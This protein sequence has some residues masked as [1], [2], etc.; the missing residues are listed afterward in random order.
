M[1]GAST[2]GA[3]AVRPALGL[4]LLCEWLRAPAACCSGG[5][6]PAA[7][8]GPPPLGWGLETAGPCPSAA[9]LLGLRT[10]DGGT[11]WLC[12]EREAGKGLALQGH[13]EEKPV[14]HPGGSS[15]PGTEPKFSGLW[16]ER[17]SRAEFG[18]EMNLSFVEEA[19][20]PGRRRTLVHS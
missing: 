18:L 12:L 14:A 20:S 17:D 5:A 15:P 11:S 9:R 2:Q 8:P 16:L 19:G 6:A 10:G 13:G 1:P 4:H 7:A 3:E